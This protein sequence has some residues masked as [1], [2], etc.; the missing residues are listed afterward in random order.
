MAKVTVEALETVRA[1]SGELNFKVVNLPP[2]IV[3]APSVGAV[4]I[5]LMRHP[6]EHLIRR[7]NWK[8]ALLSSLLRAAIFFCTNLVAG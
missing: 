6:V 5:R 2:D 7:W 4:L 8:S 1:K 3:T